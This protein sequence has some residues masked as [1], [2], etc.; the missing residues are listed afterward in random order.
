VFDTNVPLRTIFDAPTV[1]T[2]ALAIEDAA[3]AE[4]ADLRAVLD[5]LESLSD[6]EAERLLREKE[7]GN[8]V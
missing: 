7:E 5:S 3:H 6:E 4:R 2:L 8:R 1:A